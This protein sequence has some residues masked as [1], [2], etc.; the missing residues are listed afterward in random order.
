MNL[1]QFRASVA[2]TAPPPGL[3]LPLQALWWDAKGDWHR[4]HELTQQANSRGGDRVHAY[5]HRKQG[6]RS[7]ACYWYARSGEPVFEGSL[8]LEWCELATRFLR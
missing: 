8:E 5:L 4:A 7:N 3:D 1:S 6:D 2:Q